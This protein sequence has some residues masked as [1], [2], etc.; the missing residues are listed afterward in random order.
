MILQHMTPMGQEL[1]LKSG[2]LPFQVARSTENRAGNVL[3]LSAV[4]VEAHHNSEGWE[5]LSAVELRLSA[6]QAQIAQ[7]VQSSD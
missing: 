2:S 4:I 3:A 5:G 6:E 1:E 7:L